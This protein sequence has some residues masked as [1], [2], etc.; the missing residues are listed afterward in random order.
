MF[1]WA[2]G[3]QA[4][5]FFGSRTL[6]TISTQYLLWEYYAGEEI[7]SQTYF[8]EL[9]ACDSDLDGD[10]VPDDEDC[11]PESDLSP[12]VVIDGC[13]SGVF[14]L[15]SSTSTRKKSRFGV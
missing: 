2:P 3:L 13:D 8:V 6:Q 7:R 15:R 14:P 11:E 1:G 10:G 4:D 9:G 5:V 12:F